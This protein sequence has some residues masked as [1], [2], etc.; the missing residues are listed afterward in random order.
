MGESE[1]LMTKNELRKIKKLSMSR[2]KLVVEQM[3]LCDCQGK[4]ILKK[5]MLR[6]IESY[7]VDIEI[8]C[9]DCG[10]TFEGYTNTLQGFIFIN[11]IPVFLCTYYK[12]FV[13]A[14]KIPIIIFCIKSPVKCPY[15]R[16]S[17]IYR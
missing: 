9:M 6:K 3:E 12:F 15:A 16:P 10:M 4:K 7:H 13:P 11:N 5:A 1:Y 14:K 8:M 2:N 17:E